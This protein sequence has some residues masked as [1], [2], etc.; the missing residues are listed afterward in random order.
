VVT[1]EEAARTNVLLDAVY[2]SSKA[3]QEVTL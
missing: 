3:G 2:H 1:L